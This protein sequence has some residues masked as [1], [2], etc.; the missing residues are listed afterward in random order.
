M[1]QQQPRTSVPVPL[2]EVD[3]APAQTGRAGLNAEAVESYR[4]TEAE[5][6]QTAPVEVFAGGGSYFAG[7]GWH[8]G[9]ALL[10]LGRDTIM[11]HVTECDT[12]EEAQR[13]AVLFAL[14]GKGNR[15]HG[16]PRSQADKRAAVRHALLMPENEHESDRGI[17]ELCGGVS[18]PTVADV[19]IE[20]TNNGLLSGG[21]RADAPGRNYKPGAKI[22]GGCHRNEAGKIVPNEQNDATGKFTSRQPEA[23]G[24]DFPTATITQPAQESARQVAPSRP[25][26]LPN[27]APE[28]EPAPT[29]AG[30]KVKDKFGRIVPASLAPLFV[31][32][33]EHVSSSFQAFKEWMQSQQ[34][35]AVEA[36]GEA[37]GD[38]LPT[39]EQELKATVQ[40]VR[41]SVPYCVCP[42]VNGE[43]VH[44]LTGN[45]KVCVR[46]RGWISR[47]NYHQLS[48][49]VKA[50]IEELAN[51]PKSEPAPSSKPAA[52]LLHAPNDKAAHATKPKVGAA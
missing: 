3:F 30:E 33:R 26:P 20:M 11:A 10:Q 51:E 40:H 41:A 46:N 45:C 52:N 31:A 13:R 42:H 24:S 1:N 32:G 36:W 43:G 17:G 6:F 21:A 23:D 38:C 14:S 37:I 27:L 47:H 28:P 7:D 9:T 4:D 35:A 34:A 49:G 39:M 29:P 12:K 48:D 2:A 5:W 8:R 19:R 15:R 18:H 25:E 16:V 44:E 22:R 50:L